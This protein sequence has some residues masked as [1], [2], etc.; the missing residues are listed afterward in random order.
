MLSISHPSLFFMSSSVSLTVT[1]LRESP[2]AILVP[3]FP[4]LLALLVSPGLQTKPM[5]KNLDSHWF[6]QKERRCLMELGQNSLLITKCD[7]LFKSL[8]F[9]RATSPQ[10]TSNG[11]SPT[12]KLYFQFLA[13]QSSL[14]PAMEF[15][16]VN[17]I[18]KVLEASLFI[19]QART[20]KK[21]FD[22]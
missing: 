21:F 8:F 6:L 22:L 20:N 12:F 9:F 19:R 16:C 13:S 15:Q 17:Q 1:L 10:I 3:S 18:I 14:S 7:L 4:L 5:R 2:L 11:L